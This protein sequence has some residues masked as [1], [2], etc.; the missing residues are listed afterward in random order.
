VTQ[1][2]SSPSAVAP[3]AGEPWCATLYEAHRHAVLVVDPNGR[4]LRANRA[5]QWLAGG[6]SVPTLFDLVDAG[7]G[8][9]LRDALRHS[10]GWSG[11]LTMKSADGISR[12]TEC[13]LLAPAHPTGAAG[14]LVCVIERG[15]VAHGVPALLWHAGPD[16]EFDW[17]NQ[18]SGAFTGRPAEALLGLGWLDSVHPEDRER[19]VEIF[20]TSQQARVPFS[21]DLRLR[22]HDGEYRGMLV[23]GAP[24]E[25]G[26]AGIAL[27]IHERQQLETQ[28]AEHTEARRLGDVRQGNFLGALSHE[29]RGPLAPISNAASVLRTL[30]ADNP[31]LVR[32]REILERQVE[33]MRRVL[34]DLV[35]VTRALQGEITLVRERV[36]FRDVLD[37]A[38]AQNQRAMDTLGHRL[39][40]DAPGRALIVEGDSVRL[41]QMLSG[42]LG[43]ALKFTP[44]PSLVRIEARVIDTQLSIAVIDSGR[45]IAAEFLPRVFDLFAQQE[46]GA[47]SGLGVGLTLAR[48]IAQYHG[49][50]IVARSGGLGQG[51]E[52]T[53]T[54]PLATAAATS[55]D[56]ARKAAGAAAKVV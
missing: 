20:A 47:R 7:G 41:V 24:D 3:S 4:V 54:L 38:V 48:R 21:M 30:E 11:P 15:H 43:N 55:R 31:T 40:V 23:H 28:L 44:G 35:D 26:Y 14:E 25:G 33:R 51:S 34:D 37:G 27:D 19:A 53:I 49:G 12:L 17:T 1:T 9:A 16:F 13:H 42:I 2:S 22:R 45:G 52:F 36:A 10:R 46:R 32:L 6:G 5:A 8:A 39:Q 56:S 18:A 50:D 29:L